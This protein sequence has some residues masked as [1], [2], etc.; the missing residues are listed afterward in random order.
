MDPLLSP[1][2]YGASQKVY[3]GIMRDLEAHRMVPG[4]RLIETDLAQRFGVGR[5]AVR[6]AIQRL[7]VRGV[8]DPRRNKSP[9]IRVLDEAETHEI[10][11][12]ASVM[13]GLLARTAAIRFDIN[14]HGDALVS[15]M[16]VLNESRSEM[17]AD[18]FSKARR[19]FY[20]TLL[21]IGNNRELYRLFP[22][23]G[24]HIIYSQ[25]QS[26]L[27]RQ[28][29]LA[30]YRAI[31]DAVVARDPR[32]AE[33]AGKRH[34]EHVRSVIGAVVARDSITHRA[35]DFDVA[36]EKGALNSI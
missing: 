23:I 35:A 8:V 5:N 13:T 27:L 17:D 4:Q 34:V 2:P 33:L 20:R 28:I 15:T 7:A 24:M 19:Q 14:N 36:R 29:R 21:I 10:L 11:D 31:Y 22:A 25:F 6:E 26:P 18:T 9:S 16:Q 30:D 12:V 1:E 3:F 32:G